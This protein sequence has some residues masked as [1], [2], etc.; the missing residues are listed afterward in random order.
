MTFSIIPKVLSSIPLFMKNSRLTPHSGR[1][2][3]HLQE[4]MGLQNVGKQGE[5]AWDY[6]FFLFLTHQVNNIHCP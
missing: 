3:K 4:I 6:C 5:D 2:G 1:T